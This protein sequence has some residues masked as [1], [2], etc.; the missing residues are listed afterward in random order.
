MNRLTLV[1]ISGVVSLVP[2]FVLAQEDISVTPATPPAMSPE[3]ILETPEIST[4]VP[5]LEKEGKKR[6]II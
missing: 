5:V 4:P 3:P 6:E 2:F 1:A